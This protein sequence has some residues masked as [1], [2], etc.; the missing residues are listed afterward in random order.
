MQKLNGPC[1]LR[2]DRRVLFPSARRSTRWGSSSAASAARGGAPRWRSPRN[3]IQAH[4]RRSND[5]GPSGK[6]VTCSTTPRRRARDLGRGIADAPPWKRSRRAKG[7][8]APRAGSAGRARARRVDAAVL[9]VLQED[10]VKTRVATKETEER[11][12]QLVGCT[13]SESGGPSCCAPTHWHSLRLHRDARLSSNHVP[14]VPKT[15]EYP[16][17]RRVERNHRT[18]LHED[19][20][21]P[22]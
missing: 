1:G 21:A 5:S 12:L 20:K 4:L 7:C 11:K 19:G 16:V 13:Y 3:V 14:G 6:S 10:R 18:R 2:R 22:R 15:H 17:E 8:R 9:D